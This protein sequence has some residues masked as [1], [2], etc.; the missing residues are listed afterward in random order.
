MTQVRIFQDTTARWR[1]SATQRAGQRVDVTSD[2]GFT[3]R[4]EALEAA[5]DTLGDEFDQAFLMLDGESTGSYKPP[6]L[7]K[8]DRKQEMHDAGMGIEE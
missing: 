4:N 5:T 6:P 1:Y 3:T 7:P 8:V 2:E